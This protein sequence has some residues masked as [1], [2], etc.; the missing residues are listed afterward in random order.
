MSTHDYQ[1]TDFANDT[2]NEDQLEL[3]ISA[4]EGITAELVGISSHEDLET[5]ITTVTFKFA[6]DLGSEEAAL[7]A[8][9]A[10]HQG[11]PPARVVFH[12][13]SKLVGTEV[14]LTEP[15]PDGWQVLGGAVTTPSFFTPNVAAC[16]GRAVGE[17]KAVGSGAKLRITE[18]G[19]D[20]GQHELADT[21]GAW[22]KMQWFSSTAPQVGIHA[23]V[24][25]GQLDGATSAAVRFV[26]VS[27]LE[28]C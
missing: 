6:T 17:Y 4:A 22:E 13:S 5:E 15:G 24:L 10:A 12:A 14:A 23:Y 20:S 11:N 21:Q 19:V 28:F 3:E 8:L 7:D 9:V 16:R 25:E 26:A 2:F 27:L 18:D 1:H